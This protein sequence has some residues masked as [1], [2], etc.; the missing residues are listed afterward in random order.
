MFIRSVLG[1]NRFPFVPQHDQMDCGPA[2]LAMIAKSYGKT[3]PLPY[4]R[5]LSYLT[6]EGVS[7]NGLAMAAEKIGLTS[8][9]GRLKLD[10]LTEQDHLPCILYWNNGHFI[11]LYKIKSHPFTK[12]KS[13]LIA[14]PSGGIITVDELNFREL[15][16]NG[17]EKAVAM[18]L[19]PE[20][21][22]YLKIP[23][24]VER[25]FLKSM[26]HYLRPFKKEIIKLLICLCIGSLFTL[27]F[28]F[29]TQLLVDKG[30][31]GK[32][33]GIIAT[34]LLAQVSLI[35]GAVI[36]EIVR[37]WVLLYVGTRINIAIISDFF[38]KLL[39]LPIKFFDTKTLGDINQRIYDHSR[40]EQF[41]TAQSLTTLFSLINFSIFFFV[42]LSYSIT[43]V[44]TYLG[45]TVIAIIWSSFF[46]KRREH[47][48][49]FR[50]KTKSLNQE[51][52]NEMIN[53]VQELKLNNFENFKREQWEDI[54][55]KSF[56][57][58]I[59]ILS[60]D[61]LQL[62]GFDFINQFKN[63]AVTFFA[64]QQV[65]LGHISL[66][67]MLSISYII[68]QLN[69]PI[70]QLVSFLRSMQDARL[71][72]TRLTDID[73]EQEEEQPGQ[74]NIEDV[75]NIDDFD[76]DKGIHLKSVFFQYEGPSS[77]YVLNN[78]D[79]YIPEGK[80]TAIV[81]GSGSGKTTLMKLLLKIYQPTIG[82]ININ[83][84]QLNDISPSSWRNTCGI[85]MQDGY[86]FADTIE[87]NIATGDRVI[88]QANL[89]LAIFIAN[90]KDFID[91][92]PLKEKT[93]IGA[94]G[95]GLSGG[96]RQRILIARAVYKQP[97][98][99]FLDEA[100][101]SLDSEN[102]KIIQS[103]LKDFFRERTV[104]VIAHRLSTV[105]NADNL[106]VMKDGM[107]VEQGKHEE[108]V[109]LNG[110]YSRLVWHQMEAS[111]NE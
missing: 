27:A 7:L 42:L 95:M 45:M 12:L 79:L 22:F 38:K 31:G 4:L 54:Q 72:M 24:A 111:A 94:S 102:E 99:I 100:T 29:L 57:V 25:N 48:D 13:F 88:N 39:K 46:Q 107:V 3:Y 35:S 66:G 36:I 51:S 75:N 62:L 52:I 50:F 61:Q 92:L 9:T 5:S 34:I 37:N 1:L 44:S 6:R 108:L 109:S 78:I 19:E 80:M 33:M 110:D 28:P 93:K 90:I 10:E 81:G 106:I 53:G 60:I 69:S 85:V 41:L 98:F 74:F 71:S 58:N 56:G 15:W 87:R 97:K 105:K 23:P 55:V 96:Q 21:D 67:A 76:C 104:V 49:Y 89:E 8:V 73:F 101:S 30:L 18:F 2:C 26:L 47:I 64:A 65:I 82:Q 43:I 40:V 63:F 68:G 84:C 20:P 86:I 14:D 11:V 103:R 59:K 83:L 16:L 91:S 77:P 70:N 17:N 32:K